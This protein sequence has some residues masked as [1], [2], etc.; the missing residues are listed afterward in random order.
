[1]LPNKQIGFKGNENESKNTHTKQ[2]NEYVK[3]TKTQNTLNQLI[4]IMVSVSGIVG[5]LNI[6][7]DTKKI[8]KF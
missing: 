5:I 8:P 1:M 4:W 2:E 6:L 7:G 3:I